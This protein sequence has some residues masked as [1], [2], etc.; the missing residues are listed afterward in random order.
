MWLLLLM[1]SGGR[2]R[3]HQ[4]CDCWQDILPPAVEVLTG[5]SVSLPLIQSIMGITS[6]TQRHNEEEIGAVHPGT[7]GHESLL[8]L[9]MYFSE[10]HHSAVFSCLVAVG[11]WTCDVD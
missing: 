9:G 8:V 6:S 2:M 5:R 10:F 7:Q 4:H 3:E 1:V 11:Q